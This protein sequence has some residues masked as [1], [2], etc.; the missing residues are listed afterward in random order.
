MHG[1]LRSAWICGAVLLMLLACFATSWAEPLDTAR[2]QIIVRLP[3][4][5]TL[6]TDTKL[7]IFEQTDFDFLTAA[8]A[9]QATAGIW[10]TKPA[11][12]TLTAQGNV[13]YTV[14]VSIES[15]QLVSAEG[16]ELPVSQLRWRRSDSDDGWYPLSTRD[17]P[18]CVQ[19]QP[20]ESITEID[21]QLLATWDVPAATYEGTVV[22]TIIAHGFE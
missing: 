2:I 15:D 21:F 19:M 16:Y 8:D 17:E 11:A 7:L 6:D 4:L 10:V 5:V 1:K 20:G 13:G 14:T 18:V 9:A 3:M 12:L 22:Y